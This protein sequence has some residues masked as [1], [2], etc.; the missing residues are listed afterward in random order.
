MKS[1]NL[2]SSY[3][4]QVVTTS[5]PPVPVAVLPTQPL[6]MEVVKPNSKAVTEPISI[7]TTGPVPQPR[8]SLPGTILLA[9]KNG[10]RV[11]V[12]AVAG[13]PQAPVAVTLHPPPQPQVAPAPASE[14]VVAAVQA[15]VSAAA[16]V[17]NKVTVVAPTPAAVAAV[18]DEL[19]NTNNPAVVSTGQYPAASRSYIVTTGSATTNNTRQNL[20]SI[21]EAIRHL[22]GDHLFSEDSHKV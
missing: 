3:I 15:P 14:V 10:I 7:K 5:K 1:L 19:K 13:L 4:F 6:K 16:N 17:T 8:P 12:E 22:E 20:D 2:C 18:S 21:V 11:E 9:D